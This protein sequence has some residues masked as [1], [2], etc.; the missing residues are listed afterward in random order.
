MLTYRGSGIINL[1]A[2]GYAMLAGYAFWALNTGELGFTV[3]KAPA[4]VIALVF[5]MRGRR[6]RPSSASSARCATRRRSPS[7]SRRSASC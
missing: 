3:S 7:S 1:A 4:L 6:A 5:V 2:G